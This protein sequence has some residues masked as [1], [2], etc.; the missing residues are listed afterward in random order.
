MAT[1]VGRRKRAARVVSQCSVSGS[2]RSSQDGWLLGSL[3]SQPWDLGEM[4]ISGT[5]QGGVGGALGNTCGCSQSI[6]GILGKY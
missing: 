6:T 3:A 1:R 4:A 5:G 2:A